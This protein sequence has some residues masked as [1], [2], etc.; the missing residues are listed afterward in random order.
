MPTIYYKDIPT[1]ANEGAAAA[2]NAQTGWDGNVYP[3]RQ[4]ERYATLEP[5]Y[6][7]LDGSAKLL[8]AAPAGLS[9]CSTEISSA[10]GVFAEPVVLTLTLDNRYTAT[11]LT[12]WFDEAAGEYCTRLRAEWYRDSLLLAESK[13][14]PDGTQYAYSQEVEAFNRLV[15]TFYATS[16][17]QRFLRLTRLL[18]GKLEVFEGAELQR[19][20]LHQEVDPSSTELPGSTGSFILRDTKQRILHFQQRQPLEF[21]Q[22]GEYLGTLYVDSSEKSAQWLYQVD[23]IDAVQVLA[24]SNTDGGVY[25]NKSFGTLVR[26][27]I[28]GDFEAEVDP[29]LENTPLTGWL[30]NTDKRSAL[31][32]ACFAAGAM[33]TT[34]GTDRVRFVPVASKASAA[35]TKARILTG[36]KVTTEAL[37]TEV[38]VDS[39][40]YAVSSEAEQVYQDDLEPGSYTVINSEPYTG[41]SITGGT[42]TASSPNSVHFTVP[43]AGQVTITGKKYI[44]YTTRAT[45]RAA[46]AT[47]QD[48]SNAQTVED[49]TLVSPTAQKAAVQRLYDY[50]RNRHKLEQSVVYAGEQPGQMVITEKPFDGQLIGYITERTLHLSGKAVAELVIRGQN[51][52]LGIAAPD[53][54][55]V[56]SGEV[57]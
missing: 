22:G 43:S 15:I 46:T 12:F 55:T 28:G 52:E 21:W 10:D 38:A 4:N 34:A 40:R 39:H 35:I 3:E 2:G 8:P 53:S 50:S 16:V 33:V 1:G 27:I 14:T 30:P 48:K 42:I 18:V 29:A 44:D 23:C 5:G 26:E 6:W 51:V 32:Q 13:I 57:W 56:Q 41:Y 7:R 37:V 25:T 49:S 47:A 24:D 19:C 17:P 36:G 45:K 9:F 54:G 20:E 11:G 31:L